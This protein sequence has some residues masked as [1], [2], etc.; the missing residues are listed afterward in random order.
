MKFTRSSTT[1]L[2]VLGIA[3]LLA[4]PLVRNWPWYLDQTLIES[5]LLTETPLGSSEDDV[6]A[7]LQ[8]KNLKPAPVWRGTVSPHTIYPPTTVAGTSFTH[9][10]V[11]E[12]SLIFT[13]SVE[14]FYVFGQDRRLV[15]I[16]V[17]KTTDAL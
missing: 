8:A 3:C 6:L 13:T 11:G 2:V 1:A 10:V 17:R 14:A 9:A 15:E 5:R 7:H 4:V 16:A 12:Y